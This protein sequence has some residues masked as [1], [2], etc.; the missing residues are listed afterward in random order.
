MDLKTDADNDLII[1][2]G[3]VVTASP[4]EQVRQQLR[5]RIQMQVG[6]WP[7]DESAGLP[8]IG[9]IMERGVTTELVDA[10]VRSEMFR[11]QGVTSIKYSSLTIDPTTRH[12][13]GLYYVDT[14][15]GVIDVVL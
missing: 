14:D 1:S 3:D 9:T 7:F 13:T 11:I 6:E 12:L 15:Y 10:L 5:Q 8:Y 4:Q 2:H